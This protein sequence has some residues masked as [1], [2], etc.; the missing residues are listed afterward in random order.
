MYIT[1]SKAKTNE[2]VLNKI[3]NTTLYQTRRNLC[4][5][6]FNKREETFANSNY[7]IKPNLSN[8]ISLGVPNIFCPQGRKQVKIITEFLLLK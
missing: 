8:E 3:K 7:N 4:K 1:S 6:E 2:H 5:S